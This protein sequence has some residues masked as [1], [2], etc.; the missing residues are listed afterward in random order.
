MTRLHSR[1]RFAHRFT[2]A[3]VAVL[4]LAEASFA[5]PPKMDDATRNAA[6][7]L[8]RDAVA[9]YD[10]GEYK[11]ALDLLQRAH[12][13]VPAP[14]LTLHQARALSKLGRLVEAMERYEATRRTELDPKAP[15][16]F[17]D[18]VKDAGRELE[19]L[20]ERVPKAKIVV[21]GP[22]HDS[23]FLQVMLDGNQVPPALVG[24]P[25][26]ID[27][28]THRV[29]ARVPGMSRGTTTL[30]I[31]ER[32]VT[33]VQVQLSLIGAT[34]EEEEATVD[35]GARP[36]AEGSSAL[37]TWGW[38]GIGVGTAGVV[39]GA[40]G[41]LVAQGKRDELEQQCDGSQCPPEAQGDLDSFRRA[42]TI[43]YV[44]YGIGIAGLVTGTV[45]LL[46]PKKKKRETSGTRVE[47]WVGLGGAGVGGTF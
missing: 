44:G 32:E 16:A 37:E 45:L 3:L 5:A 2:Q 13:L 20:R 47:P 33:E 30:T 39:M 41:A 7:E 15:Q 31:A 8:A 43:S 26:T 4:L 28:G 17:R 38:I 23:S 25:R 46:L 14:T 42:R 27:P 34:G 40:T 10:A 24:V 36:S 11:K 18:A 22:G 6:R 19:E 35:E 21:K 1:R 9:A 12:D 29:E